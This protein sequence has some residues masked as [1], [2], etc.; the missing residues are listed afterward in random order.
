MLDPDALEERLLDTEGVADFVEDCDVWPLGCAV[1][2]RVCEADFVEQAD[3]V[4][5]LVGG[6]DAERLGETV[7]V[8][9]DFV[10]RVAEKVAR[11]DAEEVGLAERVVV[12][13]EVLVVIEVLVAEGLAGAL[14]VFVAVAV[15]EAVARGDFVVTAE[16]VELRLAFP[17]ALLV[18][19]ALTDLVVAAVRDADAVAVV[20]LD[21]CAVT[22]NAGVAVDVLEVDTDEV[23][24]RVAVVVRLVVPE[25]EV[26]F[27]SKGVAVRNPDAVAVFEGTMLRVEVKEERVEMVGHAVTVGFTEGTAVRVA[28]AVRVAD[29]EAVAVSVGS[30]AASKRMRGGP[31]AS[32]KDSQPV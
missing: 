16:G 9:E 32:K 28:V 2:E 3:A 26:V 20:V 5:D 13:T 6:A 21:A 7:E 27:V 23:A 15:V 4:G 8:R 10:L 19:V 24:E 31:G 17:E 14:R 12:V 1:L 11:A 25:A 29:L 22:V 30:T 18:V